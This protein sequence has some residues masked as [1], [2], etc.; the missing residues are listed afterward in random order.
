MEILSRTFS[1]A[2]QTAFERK[3]NAGKSLMTNCVEILLAPDKK[4]LQ[5]VCHLRKFKIRVTRFE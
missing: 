4:V 3:R 1:P 5:T 2:T